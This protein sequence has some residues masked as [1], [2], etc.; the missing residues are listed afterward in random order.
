MNSTIAFFRESIVI[1]VDL[2]RHLNEFQL[3]E[4]AY[5]LENIQK[6]MSARRKKDTQF[7]T[8]NAKAVI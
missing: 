4:L 2:R 3:D 5:V 6:D 7:T 1:E 8:E